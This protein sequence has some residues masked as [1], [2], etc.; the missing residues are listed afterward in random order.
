MWWAL[1]TQENVNPRLAAPAPSD[2]DSESSSLSGASCLFRCLS[3]ERQRL[4]DCLSF[5]CSVDGF[6]IPAAPM[7][8]SSRRT[9]RTHAQHSHAS[10]V[11]VPPPRSLYKVRA[12]QADEPP[13][14]QWYERRSVKRDCSFIDT[15]SASPSRVVPSCRSAVARI[16]ELRADVI[17]SSDDVDEPLLKQLADDDGEFDNG[18]DSDD[19]A[20]SG[21]PASAARAFQPRLLKKRRKARQL[22]LESFFRSRPCV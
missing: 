4:T 22:G 19:L 7:S 11:A 15:P 12:P 1:V 2:S 17:E 10:R 5:A 3:I 6:D 21:A 8:R 14:A 18:D 16:E 9:I 20:L 13:Q